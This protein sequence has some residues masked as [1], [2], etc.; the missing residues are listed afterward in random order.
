MADTNI[1][2]E[3]AVT[4]RATLTDSAIADVVVASER[5]FAAS[6]LLEG[7]PVEEALRLLPTIFSLCG[8]AQAVCGL[9]ATEAAL[10]IEIAAEQRA[11]RQILVASEAIAQI[12]WRLLLDVPTVIGKHPALESL[13]AVRAGIARVPRQLVPKSEWNRIGGTAL[14]INRKALIALGDRLEA[15]IREEIFALEPGVPLP[16]SDLESFEFWIAEHDSGPTRMFRALGARRLD[17]FGAADNPPLGDDQNAAV[18]AAMAA[19][20]DRSFSARPAL[21][22]VVYETGPLPR[23]RD[24]PL[25]AE[26]IAEYGKGLKA[27][28][29]AKLIDLVAWLEEY[30]A[31]LDIV[32]DATEPPA[33]EMRDGTGFAVVETARGRLFHHVRIAAG[34]IASYRILAPTEWNFQRDGA[35]GRGLIGAKGRDAERLREAITLTIMAIDPCVAFDITLVE[36]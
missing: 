27:R 23:H 20:K 10:G 28:Y 5:P 6:G 7:R 8:N 17:R 31:A 24:D 2:L 22:G 32:G 35:L 19:D 11:A 1:T 34:R 15:L 13:R 9:D 36:E 33:P 12:L 29:G 3:G 30:R 14:S 16:L 25:I 21:D 4:I 18:A 26:L